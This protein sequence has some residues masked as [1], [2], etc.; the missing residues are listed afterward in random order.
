MRCTS[1][2]FAAIWP[3]SAEDSSL[4]SRP[5]RFRVDVLPPVLPPPP[6]AAVVLLLLLPDEVLLFVVVAVVE[7]AVE[8]GE[9]RRAP[10]GAGERLRASLRRWSVGEIMPVE[11]NKKQQR[12]NREERK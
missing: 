5:F 9:V 11:G 8:G 7:V 3:R 10:R 1:Y 2:S 6:D 12:K 4:K